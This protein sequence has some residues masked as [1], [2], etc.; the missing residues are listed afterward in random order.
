L[1]GETTPAV[2]VMFPASAPVNISSFFAHYS[3]CNSGHREI[4][5]GRTAASWAALSAASCTCRPCCAL[6]HQPPT[7]HNRCVDMSSAVGCCG[8]TVVRLSRGGT[9]RQAHASSSLVTAQHRYL[10]TYVSNFTLRSGSMACQCFHRRDDILH[11][12]CGF[13]QDK[14]AAVV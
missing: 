14:W 4:S 12:N 11:R 7:R 13:M 8:N 6:H 10:R 2:A 1:P 3:Q 9:C 5:A